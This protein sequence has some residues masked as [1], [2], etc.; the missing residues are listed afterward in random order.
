MCVCVC[1]CVRTRMC[2]PVPTSLYPSTYI[3]VHQYQQHCTQYPQHYTPLYPQYYAPVP[4]ASYPS[5]HTTV[6]QYPHH[7]IPAPT[8]LSTAGSNTHRPG[9]CLAEGRGPFYP[10]T[11]ST[12]PQYPGHCT[13][14]P[15]APYPSTHS[16]IPQSP[17][18]CPLLAAIL[19][20]LV[21][22]L[23]GGGGGLAQSL[24]NMRS[25][26]QW[27]STTGGRLPENTPQKTCGVGVKQTHFCIYVHKEFGKQ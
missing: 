25:R 14:V 27:D 2:T 10:S 8:A 7:C 18:H 1:V 12:V 9:A 5:T 4:T 23:L 26:W 3:T 21:S 16:T 22:A 19:T 13:P 6:P 11:H 20:G 24:Y 17:H 15:T